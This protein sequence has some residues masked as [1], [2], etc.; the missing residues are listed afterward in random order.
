MYTKKDKKSLDEILNLSINETL[1][2]SIYTSL[3][4]II[5][6]FSILLFGPET[7]K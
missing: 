2:R 1:A 7:I 4:V 5:V 3:T 6:L